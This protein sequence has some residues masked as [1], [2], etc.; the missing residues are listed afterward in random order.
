MVREQVLVGFLV[1]S[2]VPFIQTSQK[3]QS[4]HTQTGHK[5]RINQ[6]RQNA[7]QLPLDLLKP[8]KHLA[9]VEDAPASLE[10]LGA[11]H[12]S[13]PNSPHTVV[14]LP[15]AP[16]AAA[17]ANCRPALLLMPSA[18]AAAK[19]PYASGDAI[20]TSSYARAPGT[21]ALLSI[22]AAMTTA[23]AASRAEDA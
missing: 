18:A 4:T 7:P 23:A 11:L 14:S 5:C 20:E 2:L 16:G 22:V 13:Q 6:S 17:A 3:P 10:P 19:G 12:S 9:H 21:A 1:H 8:E 15:D